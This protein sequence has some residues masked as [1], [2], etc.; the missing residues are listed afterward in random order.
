MSGEVR[1]EVVLATRNAGKIRELTPMLRAAGYEPVTLDSLR[2][3]EQAA[4]E[5]IEAFDT[6]EENAVAKA[7]WFVDRAAGRSVLA[8]D[9]GLSVNALAGA[10]GV[11]SK[12]WATRAGSDGLDQDAANNARLVRE[13]AS[14]RDR[15]AKYVCV[16]AIAWPRGIVSGRGECRGTIIEH[17][18]GT[19]GFGYDPYFLSEEL[20][21]TF[22][23]ATISDKAAV[24]HRARAVRA[25]LDAFARAFTI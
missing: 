4:E 18:R 16:A 12:R 22:G 20:G 5:A 1:R 3:E 19:S 17:P 23:E 10:P 11:R 24:S 9:S 15:S 8:D 7:R 14:H 2:L 25:T 13:L 21:V 6:F